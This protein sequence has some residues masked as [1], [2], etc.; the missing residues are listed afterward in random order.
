MG[1]EQG[2]T[3]RAAA[4]PA[5]GGDGGAGGLHRGPGDRL[6]QVLQGGFSA[7]QKWYVLLVVC[8]CVCVCMSEHACVR[9]CVHMCECVSLCVCA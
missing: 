5:G 4:L 8:V 6:A 1:A 7:L 2:Q 3:E 9:G